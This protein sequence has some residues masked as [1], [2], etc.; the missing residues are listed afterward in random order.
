VKLKRD[1]NIPQSAAP[2]SA[3][4]GY[5]VDTVLNEWLCEATRTSEP[6]LEPWAA[7]S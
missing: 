4:L 5:D 6:R 3:A 1:E 7:S 2:R